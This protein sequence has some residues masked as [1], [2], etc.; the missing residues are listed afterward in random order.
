[1]RSDSAAEAA[2][3]NGNLL[4]RLVASAPVREA[5]P[6]GSVG[7]R[8][9][10]PLFK[11]PTYAAGRAR[12]RQAWRLFVAAESAA[13]AARKATQAALQVDEMAE[14][15]RT[16]K[17]AAKAAADEAEAK[18]AAAQQALAVAEQAR[19]AEGPTEAEE[20]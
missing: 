8:K 3:P 7:G 11:L 14:L 6:V 13:R 10:G 9:S 20:E 1:V 15:K 17:D 12:E 5:L 18:A 2:V 16:L 19:E 4:E